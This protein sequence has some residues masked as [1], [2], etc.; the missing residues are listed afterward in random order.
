MLINNNIYVNVKILMWEKMGE[1]LDYGNEDSH[2]GEN[3]R[4]IRLWE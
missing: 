2:V 4:N 1:R 3:G